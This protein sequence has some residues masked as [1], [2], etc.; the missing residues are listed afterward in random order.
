MCREIAL[1]EGIL[2]GISSGAVCDAV[3]KIAERPEN[4]GKKI[5][6]ILADTGQRYLSV[7]GLFS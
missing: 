6:I 5:V 1:K 4:I 7:K 3:R 2:V